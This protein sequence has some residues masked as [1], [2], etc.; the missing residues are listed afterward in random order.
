MVQICHYISHDHSVMCRLVRSQRALLAAYEMLQ[1]PQRFC[2]H[3][4]STFRH[5]RRP[6]LGL[7]R[8]SR[9]RHLSLLKMLTVSCACKLLVTIS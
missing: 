6:T 1:Q 9:H 7:H 8:Q 3:S 4:C 2:K 5:S